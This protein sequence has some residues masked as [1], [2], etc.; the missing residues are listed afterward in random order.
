MSRVQQAIRLLARDG[1]SRANI[2]CPK[3]SKMVNRQPSITVGD[4]TIK[5]ARGVKKS[6]LWRDWK[7]M[8][9][10]EVNGTKYTDDKDP[11]LPRRYH[12]SNFF[13]TLNT[14]K[15]L[16]EGGPMA[17]LGKKACQEAL[18]ELAKDENICTYLKFGPKSNHYLEDKYADVIQRVEWQAAVE[19]GEV[20]ERLHCH[21]WLTVHHYSQVQIN[22]PVMQQMFKRMY[23][24]RVGGVFNQKLAI[25]KNPYISVKLL[26]TSDWADVIKSYI[27][28]AMADVN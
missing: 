12:E 19:T 9:T 25:T 2:K 4:A 7:R 27:H 13:I 17:E 6:G 18:N 15:T 1:R 23:N 8:S 3:V 22:M 16:K 10:M 28:K 21:I 11:S 5:P 24:Q 14:N 26:P 20:F